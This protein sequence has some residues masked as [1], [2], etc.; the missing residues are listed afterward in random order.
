MEV[1]TKRWSVCHCQ[2]QR[3]SLQVFERKVPHPGSQSSWL[4]KFGLGIE[5]HEHTIYFGT[6]PER[7]AH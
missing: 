2:M 1:N 3:K 4:R 6:Q 7:I 5:V